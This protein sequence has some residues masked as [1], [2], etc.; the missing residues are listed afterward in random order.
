M[1]KKTGVMEFFPWHLG[2]NRLKWDM[3]NSDRIT[4]TIIFA[5]TMVVI[6]A[7]GAELRNPAAAETVAYS[8]TGIQASQQ[9]VMDESF[10]DLDQEVDAERDTRSEQDAGS[11]PAQP[12]KSQGPVL[13]ARAYLVGD[14]D[15][16]EIYME[17]DSLQPLPVA[18]MSK[19]ITAFAATD[20]FPDDMPV[21]IDAESAKAPP[22][23]SNLR[24]GD[25]MT[26][27]EAL[28]PLL[29][30]SSNVAA[31]SIA[32][33]SKDRTKFL[34]SM[35]GYAWEVGMEGAFFADP[36]GV[37]PR[38]VSSAR[39]LFALARYLVFSRQDILELTR[40]PSTFL[41]STTDHGAYVFT[42]THPFVSDPR[43]I[44]GKTGRT[45]EAGE[46]MMTIMEVKGR[47][48]AVIVL[49]SAYGARASDT[50]LL[51]E[52]FE[53]EIASR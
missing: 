25:Q 52:R 50:R 37:S 26:L 3:M 8:Q 15:T 51:L 48:V 43:F 33:S 24:V 18:S 7:A 44:G 22:D 5:C 2:D 21:Y 39:G 35:S 28:Y 23:T 12:A 41:A 49:G 10:F 29:L 47:K 45:P 1:N 46:T 38:N 32:S 4:A 31:E 17:L 40:T 53:K 36:S 42:S 30:D 34:E 27:A 19:L 13:T 11:Q 20:M 14:I 9:I 6:I 16:G